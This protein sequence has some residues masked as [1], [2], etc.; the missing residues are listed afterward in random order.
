MTDCLNAS[1][2][3]SIKGISSKQRLGMIN[4]AEAFHESSLMA[5]AGWYSQVPESQAGNKKG[6]EN[7]A[8]ATHRHHTDLGE[9]RRA[10]ELG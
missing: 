7:V 1:F 10:E 2:Y 4:L 6:S 3:V 8:P 5:E 9:E